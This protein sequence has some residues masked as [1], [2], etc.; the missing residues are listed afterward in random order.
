MPPRVSQLPKISPIIL[1]ERPLPFDDPDWLFEPKFDGFR[2]LLY[3]DRDETTFVSKR[4]LLF[5]R[6]S[7]LAADVRDALGVRS[8]ILDGEVLAIDD[9]GQHT[10][11]GLM[12]GQGHLHYAAFDLLWLNGKDLRIHPLI[13]RRPRLEELIP[14]TTPLLSR[15]L[16]V[17]GE[18]RDLFE[19]VKRLD[20]EGI[21]CKR[22]ADPYD[23]KTVW[24]KVK[25]RA[26]SQ[27]TEN[28]FERF[29]PE[30]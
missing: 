28:R 25:N 7:R 18:G 30:R 15:T 6:F 17:P 1:V 3:I 26:Y 21:V 14:R 4:G 16:M 2:G 27:M 23:P 10:F 29:K 12:S 11:R 20:L 24:F 8:A 9:S 5:K 22:A 19:A 13:K